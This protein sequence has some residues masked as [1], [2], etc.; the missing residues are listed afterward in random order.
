VK[1]RSPLLTLAAV[2]L[3][4]AIMF[5]VNMLAREPGSSSVRPAGPSPLQSETAVSSPSVNPSESDEDD[6]FPQ[7]VVYAGRAED[8][9]GA[10]AVAVLNDQAAAY[11]CD[12][13]NVEFWFRGM[14]NGS[15]IALTSKGGATLQAELDGNEIKG[16]IEIENERVKFEIDEAEK[17]AGLYRAS[18]S[19]TT[20]GWIVFQDGSQVGVQTTGASSSA[21][22]QLDPTSPQV[23]VDG[24]NLNAAPI[25]GAED[26]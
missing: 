13:R 7:Q 16:E 26:L 3:A 24:E 18:G 10:V 20:I 5:I 4:F 22:P 21:A 1:H 14:V 23:T 8:N 12:G 9:A 6:K 25:S 11:F 17:P 2:A 19:K 15:D